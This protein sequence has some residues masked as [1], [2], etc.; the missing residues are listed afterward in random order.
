[1]IIFAD[2]YLCSGRAVIEHCPTA[3]QIADMWT[4]QL[5]PGPYNVFQSHFMELVPFLHS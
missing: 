3:E 1:M 4:K 5:G 2:D